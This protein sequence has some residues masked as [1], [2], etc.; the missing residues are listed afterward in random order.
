ML[1]R[2]FGELGPW[3]WMVLGFIL[4]A[5][6]AQLQDGFAQLHQLQRIGRGQGMK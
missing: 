6:P 4:L 5:G 1:Q 3:N 2:I